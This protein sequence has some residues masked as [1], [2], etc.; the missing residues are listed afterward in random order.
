MPDLVRI[1]RESTP[2][3]P[4]RPDLPIGGELNRLLQLDRE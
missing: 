1:H 4:D 3:A 2:M